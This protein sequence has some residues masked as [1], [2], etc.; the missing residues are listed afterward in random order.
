[1]NEEAN[2]KASLRAKIRQQLRT[3]SAATK[4]TESDFIRAQLTFP[5]GTRVAIFAGSPTEVQLLDLLSTAPDIE[6]FLPRIVT[7]TEM[8]FIPI[9]TS[10]KLR[11]GRFGIMEP[12][13]GTQTRI[14]DVVICP[15]LAFTKCG[16]RLGQGGG[17][18]D[19]ALE[20]FL[21]ARRI[22]VC[23]QDQ[24]LPTLPTEAHDL[25]MHEVI[26]PHPGS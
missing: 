21:T 26:T 17:F 16:S 13:E 10:S 24:L 7:G 5:P 18:Y 22:G 25:T 14:L 23:F 15:G 19:R 3:L 12:T 20:K 2:A 8:E 11:K 9:N 6:W 4:D 1:M